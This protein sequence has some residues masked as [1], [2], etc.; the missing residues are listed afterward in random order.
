GAGV[1]EHQAIRALR[2]GAGAGGDFGPAGDGCGADAG[3]IERVVIEGVG[4][5]AADADV[6]GLPGVQPDA[7][8]AGGGVGAGVVVGGDVVAAGVEDAQ[9]GVGA[10]LLGG[11]GEDV[12]SAARGRREAVHVHIAG[13]AD[14]RS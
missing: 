1:G 6:V 7:H 4:A 2:P 3:A 12:V 8:L 14:Q 10:V 11:V 13:A 5:K 9:H